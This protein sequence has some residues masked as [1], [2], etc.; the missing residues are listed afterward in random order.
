MPYHEWMSRTLAAL[1]YLDTM[2]FIYL[3][4]ILIFGIV[5]FYQL[6]DQNILMAV[7]PYVLGHLGYATLLPFAAK[8]TSRIGTRNSVLL[9]FA[10]IT[11]AA[12]FIFAFSDTDNINYFWAWM[13]LFYCG[14]LFLHSPV[15]YLFGQY[16][17]HKHRGKQMG[18]VRIFQVCGSVIAPL[19]GGFVSAEYGL[20]GMIAVGTFILLLGSFGLFFVP[21]LKYKVTITKQTYKQAPR[22]LYLIDTL[23]FSQWAGMRVWPIVMFII[24][25]SSFSNLGLALALTG[26]VTIVAAYFTG[27][28]LD[29]HDRMKTFQV[30]MALRS[31][32]WWL[33]AISFFPLMAIVVDAFNK[34]LFELTVET[35]DTLNYDLVNDGIPEDSRDEMVIVREQII[36][37]SLGTADFIGGLSAAVFGLPAALLISMFGGAGAAV[38]LRRK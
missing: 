33:R 36:N 35:L 21:N 11:A 23:F 31:F 20:P 25:G 28:W 1:I 9:A 37:Y 38:L 5:F 2:S 16:T 7:M 8:I 17:D 10:V 13:V 22:D 15:I 24:L 18:F 32:G 6:F 3:R 19:V 27:S 30:Q 14:K 34:I 26:G 4:L 12:P 29:K